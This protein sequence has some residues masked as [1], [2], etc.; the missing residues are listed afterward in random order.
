MASTIMKSTCE[1]S[2][3]VT[4]HV[5]VHSFPPTLPSQDI[6]VAK[7]PGF[8]RTVPEFRPM[9]HVCPGWHKIVLMWTPFN[10]TFCTSL[11]STIMGM[12]KRGC[13]RA[14]V[15]VVWYKTCQ[16]WD[17]VHLAVKWPER[18][19]PWI[20]FI[21]LFENRLVGVNFPDLHL[22]KTP[23]CSVK[24]EPSISP[25]FHMWAIHHPQ[26][27]PLEFGINMLLTNNVI[28]SCTCLI[29]RDRIHTLQRGSR[30]SIGIAMLPPRSILDFHVE[31]GNDLTPSSQFPWL[32]VSNYHTSM[33][34]QISPKMS[35]CPDNP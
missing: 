7:C 22:H 3:T 28:C 31:L 5:P 21:N 6:T 30:E 11:V 9:S 35:E 8:A 4:V 15:P 2:M 20:S 29:C 12:V 25:A 32:V 16:P 26:D 19:P 34:Q 17:V 23:S 18:L 24:R 10:F 13:C 27:T 14:C 33:T 1:A